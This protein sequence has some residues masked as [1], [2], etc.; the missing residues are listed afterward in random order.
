MEIK[1]RIA[2]IL[3]TISSIF[4]IGNYILWLLMIGVFGE[5]GD[6]L[7]YNSFFWDVN[8]RIVFLISVV[9]VILIIFNLKYIKNN[10]IKFLIGLILLVILLLNS[11]G[12]VVST[13]SPAI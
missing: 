13:Y 12:V 9:L 8:I 10:Y 2:Y 1:R 3:F 5:K 11:C 7:F 4:F 6:H